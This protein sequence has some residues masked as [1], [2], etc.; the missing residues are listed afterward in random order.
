MQ[1]KSKILFRTAL[2]ISII[3]SYLNSLY[4]QSLISTSM[5]EYKDGFYKLS[6]EG[7]H[8]FQRNLPSSVDLSGSLYFPPVYK[9]THWVCNQVAASYYMMTYETNLRK[10]ISSQNPNN[11]FSVYFPWNFNNG[12]NGW[13]GGNYILTFEFLKKQGVLLMN[14]SPADINRDSSLWVNGYNLYYSAM[15]NRIKDYYQ[16]N[17]ATEAGI[18]SLKSWIYNH[19]GALF[20]GGLATF[21]ANIADNGAFYLTHGTPHSGEY[22]IVRCGNDALHARTIV[23]YDDSVCFDYNNDG[24]YTNNIDLNGDGII[25]VRDWEKGAFKLAESFGPEWQGSGFCWIMYKAMADEYGHGGILNNRV[26][27]IEPNLNYSPALTAKIKIKHTSRESLKIKIGICADTSSNVPDFET[28]FP[29]INYQG[30]NYFMQG[31]NNEIHKSLEF[32]LDL[33]EL[34]PYFNSEN[35][36][37]IIFSIYEFDP[38]NNNQGSIEYFSILDYTSTNLKETNYLNVPLQINNNSITS[39]S[40]NIKINNN[41]S[42]KITTE[43]LPVFNENQNIWFPLIAEGGTPPYRW[44]I[45]THFEQTKTNEEYINF[46]GT[47]LTPNS[48]FD[49]ESI[50]NLG[51]SLKYNNSTTQKIKVHTNGVVLPNIKTTYW[52]QI[53][54]LVYPMFINETMIAPLLRH[55][56]VCDYTKGDGIWYNISENTVN[57]RWKVSEEWCESWTNAEFSCKL[58]ADGK[59]EFLYG[60]R[61][62]QKKYPDIGGVSFGY[63]TNNILSF[64]NDIPPEGTKIIITPYPKPETININNDGVLY[65]NINNLNNYPISIKLTDSKNISVVKTF[66]LYT[67]IKNINYTHLKIFPNPA[68]D[69]ITIIYDDNKNCNQIKYSIYSISGTLIKE[70]FLKGNNQNISIEDLVQGQYIIKI[71]TEQTIIQKKIIKL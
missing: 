1:N 22:A 19:S 4:S 48:Y 66:Y 16:L 36:A 24:Q 39:F 52:T 9:Q 45:I 11:I 21:L 55:N 54:H 70:G 12:G 62:L 40:V 68:K 49:G 35:Y 46:A 31:G 59:V 71:E 43:S 56:F 63:K 25:D 20:P 10:G 57:I 58:F 8:Y 65:G 28:D 60:P 33:T 27:I 51:F 34:L 29:I 41:N 64:L 15:Q 7:L 5:L 18:L 13:Y 30:G 47:K 17:T 6:E 3:L 67:N 32:G 42:P 2:I 37:K 69:I 38:N 53:Y 14:N 23:G 26:H 61:F 50:I 44:E